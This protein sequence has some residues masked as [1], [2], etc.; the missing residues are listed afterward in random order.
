MRWVLTVVIYKEQY[1]NDS[2]A[3]LAAVCRFN[4]LSLKDI[5]SFN[6]I[7]SQKGQAG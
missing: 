1:K 3:D 6:Y 5:S 4:I 7:T 2:N